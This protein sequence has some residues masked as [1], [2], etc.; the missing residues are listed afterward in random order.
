MSVGV[1]PV[2]L[3]PVQLSSGSAAEQWAGWQ[4]EQSIGRARDFD[5]STDSAGG[6][7]T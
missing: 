1:V 3:S 5:Y 2:E 7:V 4:A 6:R